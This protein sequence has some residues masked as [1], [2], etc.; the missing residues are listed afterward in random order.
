MAKAQRSGVWVNSR[1]NP[2]A[3]EV[4]RVHRLLRDAA[5]GAKGSVRV[6]DGSGED[7][8]HLAQ[9]FVPIEVP[10]AVARGFSKRSA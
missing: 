2:A 9:F 3:L 7:C 1:G 10:P 5:E 6:I 8:L 4:R